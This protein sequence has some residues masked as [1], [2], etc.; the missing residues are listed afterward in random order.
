MASFVLLFLGRIALGYLRL[1]LRNACYRHPPFG[2][3]R[4]TGSRVYWSVLAE[5][6]V[7][8]YCSVVTQRGDT[9]KLVTIHCFTATGHDCYLHNLSYVIT[10]PFARSLAGRV[11][12]D[13]WF[14]LDVLMAPDGFNTP[15]I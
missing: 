7:L 12:S 2:F 13:R 9:R 15:S 4:L 8:P 1:I 14:Y 10:P 5:M 6:V 3:H 11:K